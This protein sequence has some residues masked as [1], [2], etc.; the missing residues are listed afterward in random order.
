MEGSR[1]P[2]MPVH[3]RCR[4]SLNERANFLSLTW[5]GYPSSYAPCSKLKYSKVMCGSIQ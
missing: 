5:I 3:V 4:P 2:A 1:E